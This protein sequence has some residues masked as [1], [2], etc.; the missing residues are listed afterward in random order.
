[1]LDAAKAFL[2]S[3]YARVRLLKSSARGEVWLVSDKA[4]RPCVLR[5]LH[6]GGLPFALLKAHQEVAPLWPEIYFCA[7]DEDE[8]IV[9]EEYVGGRS[10]EERRVARTWLTE[11]EARA[12][13]LSLADGLSALHALGIVHRDIKPAH[14]FVR[15]NGATMTVRLIDFDA[16][17][18]VTAGAAHDTHLLGTEGY[19]PPEQF[20]FGATDGRSDIYALGVTVREMMG[21][22]FDA[23]SPLGKILLRCTEKDPDRRYPSAQALAAALRPSRRKTLLRSAAKLSCVSLL[24]LAL[25][26]GALVLLARNGAAPAEELEQTLE[27]AATDAG[28]A[29]TGKKTAPSGEIADSTKEQANHTAKDENGGNDETAANRDSPP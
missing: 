11:A 26:V 24:T 3:E 21:P 15:G 5:T 16:A 13:S 12:L 10:L 4:G 27:E 18:V 19:A 28:D 20:G 23:A 1:M 9:V 14:V 25:S 7:E 29:L 22:S 6:A 2:A 8:T 17:R